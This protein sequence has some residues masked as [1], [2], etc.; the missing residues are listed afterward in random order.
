MDKILSMKINFWPWALLLTALALTSCSM[1]GVS[2]SASPLTPGT[3]NGKRAETESAPAPEQ[4]EAAPASFATFDGS[5]YVATS[6]PQAELWQSAG[7]SISGRSIDTDDSE[8]PLDCTLY[9][10]A[11]V[12]GQWVGGCAGSVSIPRYGADHIAVMLVHA[13][14]TTEMIQVAPPPSGP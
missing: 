13:D 6:Q 9:R 7:W 4:G 14:G 11:G 3:L 12:S 5:L 8:T 10:H 1:A 2:A